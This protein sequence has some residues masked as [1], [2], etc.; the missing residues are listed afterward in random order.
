M[1][2]IND[3]FNNGTPIADNT[4]GG[5]MGWQNTP[6]HPVGDPHAAEGTEAA[7]K[8]PLAAL[9]INCRVS[10]DFQKFAIDAA[11]ACKQSISQWMQGEDPAIVY[12]SDGDF[13]FF[14]EIQDVLTAALEKNFGFTL[15]YLPI[16]GDEEDTGSEKDGEPTY[17]WAVVPVDGL[18]AELD[19]AYD[20]AI[21]EGRLNLEKAIADLAKPSGGEDKNPDSGAEG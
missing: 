16:P 20:H 18:E 13:H 15:E 17:M 19:D 1:S 2:D 3:T 9:F 21:E 12:F 4:G 5:Q 10:D 14:C 8:Y 6:D 11:L 7:V